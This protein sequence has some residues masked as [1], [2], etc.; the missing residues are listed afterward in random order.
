MPGVEGRTTWP[1]FAIHVS[2][3]FA[4]P[5]LSESKGSTRTVFRRRQVTGHQ[6]RVT[7]QSR[8]AHLP[9]KRRYAHLFGGWARRVP[10]DTSPSTSKPLWPKNP[11]SN[12]QNQP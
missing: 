3:R 8:P 1:I 7:A 2:T 12:A 10:L 4:Q 5:V 6:S 9:N 11:I